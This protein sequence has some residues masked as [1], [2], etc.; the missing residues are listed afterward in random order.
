MILKISTNSRILT[1][2]CRHQFNLHYEK[3]VVVKNLPI[4]AEDARNVSLIPGSERSPGGG[5][6][7][8]LQYSCLGNSMDRGAWWATVHGVTKELDVTERLSTKMRNQ[9]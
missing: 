1:L 7:N 3:L 5:N 9:Y 4:S 8:S 2:V 6:G